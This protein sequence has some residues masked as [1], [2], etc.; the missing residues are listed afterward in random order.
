MRQPGF[1]VGG[2]GCGE[3]KKDDLVKWIGR[4]EDGFVRKGEMELVRK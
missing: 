2:K 3:V 4:D 1:V